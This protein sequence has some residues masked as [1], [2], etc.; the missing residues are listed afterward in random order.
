MM[1]STS[2]VLKLPSA[3]DEAEGGDDFGCGHRFP[4]DVSVARWYAGENN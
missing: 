4:R 3:E 2:P 1:F